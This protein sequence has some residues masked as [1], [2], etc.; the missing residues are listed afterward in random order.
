[1]RRYD[2]GD[3]AWYPHSL[4]KKKME[5]NFLWIGWLGFYVVR[6]FQYYY[7]VYVFQ[8]NRTRKIAKKKCTW[9]ATCHGKK[10]IKK[11]VFFIITWLIFPERTLFCRFGSG[12]LPSRSARG[13]GVWVIR[14]RVK[15]HGVVPPK[16][17]SYNT[18][19]THR[20]HIFPIFFLPMLFILQV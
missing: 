7:Y 6:R 13:V 17:P 3:R 18:G 10:A 15:F 14:V 19:T 1:M 8:H 11:N 20:T 2:L 4:Q 5:P 9:Y 16:I 12:L